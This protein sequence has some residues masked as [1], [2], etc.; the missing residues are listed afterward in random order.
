VFAKAE[1]SV[2]DR[3][4]RRIVASTSL[5]L[6]AAWLPHSSS[7]Q[8][9][10]DPSAKDPIVGVWAMDTTRGETYVYM[11]TVRPNGTVGNRLLREEFEGTWKRL[12]SGRYIMTPGG[13]DDYVVLR[14]GHLE[15]WDKT[16]FIRSFDRVRALGDGTNST[17]FA[18]AAKLRR[19]AQ[20]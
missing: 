15:E 8:Q 17:D 13:D 16:G 11:L 9:G 6:L 20:S 5:A 2:S 19:E 1:I 7:A 4:Y 18:H 10:K 12:K 3:M 14:N